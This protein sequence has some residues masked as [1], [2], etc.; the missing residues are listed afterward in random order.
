MVNKLIS[1]M[2]FMWI[3]TRS[4]EFNFI[5]FKVIDRFIKDFYFIIIQKIYFEAFI[6]YCC[7][8]HI[9]LITDVITKE[10]YFAYLK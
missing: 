8:R 6:A 5:D 7:S 9:K 3:I 2:I 1:F 10:V 4:M